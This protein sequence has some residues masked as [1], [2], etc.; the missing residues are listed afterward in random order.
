MIDFAV[1]C[2]GNFEEVVVHGFV[3]FDWASDIDERR[4]TSGYAFRLLEGEVSWMSR[5]QLLVSLSIN[6]AKY[7]AVTYAS[8]EVVWLQ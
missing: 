8:K 6:E 3:D 4:S 5:R 7:M 2:Q 1:Y